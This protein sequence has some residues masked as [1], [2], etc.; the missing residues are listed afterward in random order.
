MVALKIYDIQLKDAFTGE[1]IQGSGGMV[2]V[3]L[4][5]SPDKLT[6]YNDDGTSLANPV[7]L[8][9]GKLHFAVDADQN[10]VDLYGISPTGHGFVLRGLKPGGNN[11]YGINTQQR[12]TTW[13]IPFSHADCTDNVEKDSGFDLPVGALVYPQVAIDVVDTD[14][15]ETVL[16]GPLSSE[17]GGDA[18]GFGV[19]LSLATAGT[20]KATLLNSGVTLGAQLYV[21]DSANSG[22]KAPE[23]YVVGTAKSVS[24]TTSTGTDTGS[25]FIVLNGCLAN[26]V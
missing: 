15:T 5:G 3:C 16:F 18:D 24:Y 25:G 4:A 10:T 26:I 13:V 11:E 14:A 1:I 12:Q 23:S 7:S 21:Q 2:Q 20:V 6:L 9:R 8:V 19:G 22:D 17:S